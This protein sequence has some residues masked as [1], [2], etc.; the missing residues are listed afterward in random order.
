MNPHMTITDQ[1]LS[2]KKPR[3]LG[4]GTGCLNRRSAPLP[5]M[6]KIV[7]EGGDNDKRDIGTPS[8]GLN[9]FSKRKILNKHVT[10]I[11]V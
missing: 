7:K 4:N 9:D 2:I 11:A 5:I 10:T 6:L 8:F 1:K 3:S